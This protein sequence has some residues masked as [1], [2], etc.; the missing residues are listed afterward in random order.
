MSASRLMFCINTAMDQ[1]DIDL[2]ITA[3]HESLAELRPFVET[4]QPE[5]LN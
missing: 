2:A 4:A 5:L 3:M 1:S